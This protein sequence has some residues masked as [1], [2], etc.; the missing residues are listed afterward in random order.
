MA[1]RVPIL[2]CLGL[3][4]IASASAEDIVVVANK[5]ISVDKLSRDQIID[6]FM[7]RNR[8]ISRTETA[9]PLDLPSALPESELFYSRLT[10]KTTSEIKAYWARLIFTG[11]AKPPILA[12]SQDEA[13]RIVMEKQGALAYMNRSMINSHVKIV[14]E[15]N[16]K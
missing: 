12:K 2:L 6:I 5:K 1:N 15:L 10:G 4:W 16:E 8:D 13:I 9:I 11:R 7:G 14:F 3:L